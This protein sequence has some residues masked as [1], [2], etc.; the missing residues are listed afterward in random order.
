MRKL[1]IACF[2]ICLTCCGTSVAAYEGTSKSIGDLHGLSVEAEYVDRQ[3]LVLY[4][5]EES[6]IENLDIPKEYISRTERLGEALDAIEVFEWVDVDELVE[7]IGNNPNVR[8]VDVNENY[9][10]LSVMPNDP[11]LMSNDWQYKKIGADKTWDQVINENPVGVAVVDS[12]VIEHPDLAGRV[13]YNYDY[14]TESEAKIDLFGHGTSVIGCINGVANNGIGAA[15]VAGLSKVEVYAYRIGGLNQFDTNLNVAYMSEAILDII[16]NQPEVRVVNL[17]FG[18]STSN[19]V[20]KA[21]FED[22]HNSG[23]VIVAASGN[24]AQKGNPI[25]YP[26][27]YPNVV[28]VGA[29]TSTNDRASYSQYNEFVDLVA[30]G[31]KIATTSI[32]ASQYKYAYGTSFASPIVAGCAAVLLANNPQLTNVEVVEILEETALDLGSAGRDP[33]YGEGLVQL[34]KALSVEYSDELGNINGDTKINAEDAL[35]ALRHSV[36][37]ETLTGEAFRKGDVVKDDRVNA[38][39]ALEILRYAVGLIRRF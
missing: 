34:D 20:E 11:H 17:S 8:A 32:D 10:Q 28:S 29:T 16:K 31:D 37:L 38:E 19:A 4:N 39:D 3:I 24:G 14:V 12:G 6:N 26:A 25:M 27:S 13:V 7:M 18:K 1:L 22:L 35:M 23:R 30:P 21:L 36:G 15:G 33:E 9:T 2:A 5:N